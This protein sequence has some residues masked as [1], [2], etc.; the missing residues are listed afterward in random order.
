MT[1][2]TMIDD[3]FTDMN[4]RKVRRYTVRSTGRG[5]YMPIDK[6]TSTC[7]LPNGDTIFRTRAEVWEW[8][9]RTAA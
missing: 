7:P 1:E 9:R 3:K 8:L 5:F 4:G 2:P 6:L